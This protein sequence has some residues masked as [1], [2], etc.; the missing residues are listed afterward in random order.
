MLGGNFPKSSGDA[1][2]AAEQLGSVPGM[3]RA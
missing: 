1:G 2:Q 3:E